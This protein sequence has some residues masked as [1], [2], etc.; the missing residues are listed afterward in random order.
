M[1]AVESIYILGL[2]EGRTILADDLVGTSQTEVR[3]FEFQF[4]D[5]ESCPMRATSARSR[6][7]AGRVAGGARH[8]GVE[9]AFASLRN[10]TPLEDRGEKTQL[11]ISRSIQD[12]TR[13]AGEMREV[14]ATVAEA[15]LEPLMSSATGKRQQRAAQFESAL[16]DDLSG[17]LDAPT[18]GYDY[19]GATHG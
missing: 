12:G 11:H 18:G 14:A 10:L 16:H 3:V 8:F 13:R 17:L 19:D 4:P 5:S 1:S 9:E 2:G 7:P 6:D 15:G